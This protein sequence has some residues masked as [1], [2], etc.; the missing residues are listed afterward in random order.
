MQRALRHRGPDGADLALGSHVALAHTRLAMVDREGGHQPMRSDDGRFLLVYNGELYND[1]EL[2]AEL[3][4][5]R[6]RTRCD[7]ETVLAAWQRWGE[8]CI[9]RL[10]G[11]FAFFVW[12]EARQVGIAARDPL[13][14]KPLWLRRDGA[15]GLAFASEAKA[16]L[17][18]GPGPVRARLDAVVEC[19]VAPAFSGVDRSPFEGIEAL[20]P[21][22]LLRVDAEGI[23][24]RE[25]WRW[26]PE[27]DPNVSA[28][29][30]C[31]DLLRAIDRC[32]Q[33]DAPVGTFL[34]GG[35]DS[36]IIA[37]RMRSR[38]TPVDALT[39]T[40]QGQRSWAERASAVVVSD[41][42]PFARL[43]A[44]ELGLRHHW[45]PFDRVRL[46]D[47]LCA[48][49]RVDDALPAWEQELSQRALARAAAEL[50]LRGIVV[51]DAADETHY[52]YHFLLD[53]MATES[54]R[55]IL[56]RLG[57]VPLRPE[58]EPDP[59]GALDQRYRSLVESLGTTYD[60][61]ARR[62]EATTALVI[63]RW[64][65]RLL[66]NG[67]VHC[68]AFGI[69]PRVPFAGRR[70]LERA[71]AIAPARAL[72]GG[73]EKSLL[74]EAARGLVPE[75]I[76]TR[77]KSALPKDQDLG[78][79]YLELLDVLRAEPHPLVRTVV[80]LDRMPSTR[81]GRVPDERERAAIFRVLC[82]QRWAEAH[83][84]AA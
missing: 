13:G 66:H 6:F 32:A 51:G 26:R 9:D 49:A 43:A 4:D 71:R 38:G 27:P 40:F 46:D 39:I 14:V 65:P 34:S 72:A 41:D 75:A 18:L 19:L 59:V 56:E 36:T 22:H 61:P 81:D 67:D 28:E 74:R 57:T 44:D 82:L 55:R 63:H 3:S 25:H 8:S 45:V 33:A 20:P 64:L 21:G 23:T 76:R 69:E 84:V 29:A 78:P 83:G 15:G 54:P 58:I 1:A 42:T 35:L 2:R 53:A 17:G 31:D 11:M 10:D 60:D 24:V 48:L 50:G 52:G 80:D 5:H 47:E 77:R 62:I 73:V 68:M 16:L 70:V 30:L 37:A 7:A 12:D 79:P